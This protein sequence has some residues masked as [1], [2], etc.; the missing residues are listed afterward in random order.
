MTSST[1]WSTL[2]SR[3]VW[4]AGILLALGSSRGLAGPALEIT[5]C[6]ILDDCY[7]HDADRA[8]D[9]GE[10]LVVVIRVEN[11]GDASADGIRGTVTLA[12]GG[13][14]VS[15]FEAFGPLAPLAPGGTFTRTAYV[16]ATAPCDE[17]V[18]VDLT[19]LESASGPLPP[20][21]A[22]CDFVVGAGGE[23][24]PCC[25]V[26]DVDPIHPI[27]AAKAAP[28]DV[29]LSWSADPAPSA[30]HYN[31]YFV[32]GFENRARISETHAGGPWA[33]APECTGSSAKSCRH[34]GAAAGEAGE[35]YYYQVRGMCASDEAAE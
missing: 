27:H 5:S 34:A 20:L 7:C 22:G 2:P 9:P 13:E 31:T 32:S 29:L 24:R 4:A 17:L 1:A 19:E 8:V 18:D 3:L 28:A 35:L 10:L 12:Q 6:S 33:T 16:L 14:P 11:T 30:S 26:E 21:L 25:E 15:G 23:C